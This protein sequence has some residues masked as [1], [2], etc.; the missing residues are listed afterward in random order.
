M[1]KDFL[2]PGFLFTG[3]NGAFDGRIEFLQFIN[4]D[5]GILVECTK[6]NVNAFGSVQYSS[7]Q[8]EWN[9]ET[10][11]WAFQRGDYYEKTDWPGGW[12]K[13]SFQ[14]NATSESSTPEPD[15]EKVKGTPN[16]DYIP[17]SDVE[18]DLVKMQAELKTVGADI[19]FIIA[20]DKDRNPIISAPENFGSDGIITMLEY[21]IQGIKHP[22]T[23]VTQM[24]HLKPNPN[25]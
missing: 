5:N 12:P 10:V 13:T 1:T 19:L 2:I 14:I 20:M 4:I 18:L 6:K 11:L 8:E 17:P 9:L 15:Y 22:S 24:E 25:G 7:W 23:Q 3:R 16:P 21:I